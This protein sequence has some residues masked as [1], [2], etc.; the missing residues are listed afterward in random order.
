MTHQSIAD[1]STW[2]VWASLFDRFLQEVNDLCSKSTF[3]LFSNF[4][5]PIMQ[6]LRYP[7]SHSILLFCIHDINNTLY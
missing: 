6:R 2:R 4:D 1:G 5:Q 7:E 3:F